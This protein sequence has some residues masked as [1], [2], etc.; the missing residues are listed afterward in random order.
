MRRPL[1]RHAD[2]NWELLGIRQHD[3]TALDE[4]FTDQEIKNAIGHMP[5]DRAPAPSSKHAGTS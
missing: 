5:G 1:A 2:F 4:P 3:M